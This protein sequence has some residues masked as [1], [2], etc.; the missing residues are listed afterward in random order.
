MNLLPWREQKREQEKRRFIGFWT[1]SSILGVFTIVIA[2]HYFSRF[3]YDQILCNQYLEKEKQIL[4]EHKKE[5]H[6]LQQKKTKLLSKISLLQNLQ[7]SRMLMVHLLDELSKIVP[8]GIYLIQLESKNDWVIIRG[9]SE[10]NTAL[11]MFMNNIEKNPWFQNPRLTEI[12]KI[13]QDSRP[14]SHEF[15]L[16]FLLHSW[17]IKK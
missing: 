8:Y 11:S 10:S 7:S 4:N 6:A 2:N 15:T 14:A 9:H 3:L 12:K 5:I 17:R 16:R 13:R 1:A